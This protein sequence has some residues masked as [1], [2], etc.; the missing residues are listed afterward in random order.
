MVKNPIRQEADQMAI[1]KQ[2]RGVELGATEKQLPIV[3]RAG[4]ESGTSG[5]EI[6]RPNHSATLSPSHTSLDDFGY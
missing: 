6:Q 4:L 3:V 1:C 2:G 5:L